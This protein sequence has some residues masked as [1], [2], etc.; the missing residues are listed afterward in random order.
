MSGSNHPI[1]NAK[2]R[3]RTAF[4]RTPQSWSKL[5]GA[6]NS[7]MDGLLARVAPP[8]A[9]ASKEPKTPKDAERNR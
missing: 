5:P 6:C 1:P 4:F 2:Q 7:L 8:G 3:H 9:A